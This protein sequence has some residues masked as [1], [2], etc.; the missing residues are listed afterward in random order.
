MAKLPR[1]PQPAK[2]PAPPTPRPPRARLAPEP[3]PK[4]PPASPHTRAAAERDLPA[5]H[6]LDVLEERRKR[7]DESALREGLRPRVHYPTLLKRELA[8]TGRSILAT[9][10]IKDQGELWW[11]YERLAS[12]RERRQSRGTFSLGYDHGSADGRAER[13]RSLAPG[14]DA[15]AKRIADQARALVVQAGLSP[16]EATALLLETAWALTLASPA[17]TPNT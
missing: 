12:E 14:L 7:P 4:A 13:F 9:L 3:Q 8:R 17:P 16:A 15:R 1:R 11:Q 10:R 6:P 2:P 5:R